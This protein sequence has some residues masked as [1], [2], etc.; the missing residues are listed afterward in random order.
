MHSLKLQEHVWAVCKLCKCVISDTRWQEIEVN[1][2]QWAR[3]ALINPF[4]NQTPAGL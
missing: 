1:Y 3:V 4:K 2:F